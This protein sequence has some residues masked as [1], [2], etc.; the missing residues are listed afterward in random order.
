[1]TRTYTVKHFNSHGC[2]IET[3]DLEIEVSTVW[4]VAYDEGVQLA[5]AVSKW[6]RESMLEDGDSLTIKKG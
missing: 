3:K 4:T 6:L 5:L 2:E 1:M